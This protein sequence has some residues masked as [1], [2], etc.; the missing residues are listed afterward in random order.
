MRSIRLKISDKL[1]ED[2]LL[3]LRNFSKGEVEI[4]PEDENFTENQQYLE[5]ELREVNEGN[6]R[7]HS[8]NEVNERLEKIIKRH[9]NNL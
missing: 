5:K 4:I 1:Y 8:I 2:L 9:E 6:A 7:F 3:Y